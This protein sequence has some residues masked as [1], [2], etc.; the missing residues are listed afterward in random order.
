[1]LERFAQT[2]TILENPN[3]QKLK[4]LIDS[5]IAKNGALLEGIIK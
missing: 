1:M 5:S 2:R 3:N 4:R